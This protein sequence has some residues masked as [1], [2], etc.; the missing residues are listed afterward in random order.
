MSEHFEPGSHPAHPRG[1]VVPVKVYVAVF[2]ALCVLTVV[3][4][5]VTGYDFGP[6]NLI[7]A[8]G[9]A[10]AKASLVV[11]YFMHARYSPKLTGVVIVSSIAFFFILVFLTLTDYV[12]RPWPV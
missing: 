2:L 4:V 1:H 7:V 11:L 3:T 8:L 5:A 6:F 9:V 12:S 10:I